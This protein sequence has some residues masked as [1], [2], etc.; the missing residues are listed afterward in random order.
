MLVITTPEQGHQLLSESEEISPTGG[1]AFQADALTL[2]NILDRVESQLARQI[3]PIVPSDLNDLPEILRKRLFINV[4][5]SAR[6]ETAKAYSEVATRNGR[7]IE[8]LSQQKFVDSYPF[9]PSLLEI[10]TSRMSANTNFQR[11]RGTLR[12]LSYTLQD[13]QRTNDPEALIH[14]SHVTPAAPNIRM[15]LINRTAFTELDPAIDTD[16]VGSDATVAKLGIEL[17]QPVANT[18]LMGTIAPEASSGLYADDIADA[19]LSPDHQDYG[20]I[21]NAIN[22]FLG[23][24]IYVDDTPSETRLRRF[25]RE[26]N[27]MK[28]LN[29]ARETLLANTSRMEQ[30]LRSAIQ[31]AYGNPTRRADTFDVVLYPTRTS[32]L[33]DDHRKARLGIINPDHWIWLDADNTA[34]GMSNQDIIE[35]HRHSSND[36]GEAPRQFPNNAIFLAAH[37]SDLTRIRQSIATMEAADQLLND[38]SRNLPEHRRAILQQERAEAEKNVTT[39][40][41]NKWTHLFSAGNSPQHQWPE[42]NSHLETRTLE[43]FTDAVGKGQQAILDALGDRALRGTNAALNKMVWARIGIIA[44]KRRRNVGAAARTLR[45]E[46]Q[47]THRHQRTNLDGDHPARDAERRSR[48]GDSHRRNKSPRTALRRQLA[49]MGQRT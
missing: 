18:M 40:I 6:R 41:Q 30:S 31:S 9:H 15:E 35:L 34:N 39:D 46:P 12:L 38:P 13:M 1:D 20:L 24:A 14:P 45:Q 44:R 25:S 37:N 33:P 26:A 48:R 28:E 3:N 17:A 8:R 23:K 2:R 5:E 19:I 42:P 32:N 49:S 4:D 10:I 43:S 29:E 11:V 27:I 7:V 22:T 16:V 36:N 21:T 47:R